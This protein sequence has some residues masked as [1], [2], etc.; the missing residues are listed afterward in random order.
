MVLLKQ[1]IDWYLETKP[2]LGDLE[3][4]LQFNN[5]GLSINEFLNLIEEER[6]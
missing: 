6:A 2:T 4:E 1:I 5:I 3:Y